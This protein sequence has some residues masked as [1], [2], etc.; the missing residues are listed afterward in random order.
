ML[1]RRHQD[2]ENPHCLK[3][4]EII[5]ARTE[6]VLSHEEILF[7]VS[8][9]GQ[10]ER[11]DLILLDKTLNLLQNKSSVEKEGRWS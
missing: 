3:G 8:S 11:L 5:K 4:R 2:G 6:S 7:N 9:G 10:P 1:T